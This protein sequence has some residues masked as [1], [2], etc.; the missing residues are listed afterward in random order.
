MSKYFLIFF[1]FVLLACSKNES[2]ADLIIQ[3]GKIYT[4]EANNPIVEAVAVRGDKIIFVGLKKD[5]EKF[6]GEK[7]QLIDLQGTTITPG[8]I[9]GHGHLF[10]LGFNELNVNLA[11][12]KNYEELV[13]KI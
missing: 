2:P 13:A 12:V 11:N 6:K 8:L 4:A 1:L 10:G 3:G 5:V 9:E 7:T